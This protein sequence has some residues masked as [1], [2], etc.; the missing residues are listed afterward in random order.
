MTFFRSALIPQAL[1]PQRPSDWATSQVYMAHFALSDIEGEDFQA[2]ERFERGAAG[3]AGAQTEPYRVWLEDWEVSETAPGEYKLYASR[4]G[5]TVDLTLRDEKG[6]VPQGDQ[7]YSQKG[8]E[9]GDASY[10]YSQTRLESEGRI[11][12]GGKNYGV[13]G[14]SWKDHE[15]STS[16]L[17]EG[18]V[19]WDW[20]AIQ[21]GDGSDLMVYQLRRED[22]SV[23]PFSSGTL[24]RPDG[25]TLHL[26]SSD[27]ELHPQGTWLSPHSGAEY[28]AG[29]VVDVPRIG[30]RVNVRP[31]L[32]DQE[33]NLSFIYW[34][35]AVTVSGEYQ[36]QAI[37]GQGYLEMTGYAASM[38]GEF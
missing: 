29:W 21:L 26:D 7:G 14:L 33:L 10:Y 34:E 18:Q 22:G 15:Y 17:S 24:V 2:F 13:S 27:F 1:V 8:P 11:T 5:I 32:S 37:G 3:L 35:G 23:D 4:E 30:L 36:G 28:P 9:P 12:V 25:S 38:E 16:A 6:P 20:F 31:L 19:G